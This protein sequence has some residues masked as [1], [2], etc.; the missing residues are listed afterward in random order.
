MG[1][2]GE[3][4]DSGIRETRVCS[5]CKRMFT[6][7]GFGHYYCP[8]CKKMD[9]E[10][11][12]RVRDYIYDHGSASAMEV[13]EGTGVSLSTITQYLKEGRLEI[14][15]NSLIF[16]KCEMCG[17]NIRS[18][19]LCRECASKLNHVMRKEIEF[20][21]EQIGEKPK[22]VSGKMRFLDNDS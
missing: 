11:F 1:Q 2:S 13:S 18:G 5:R 3:N 12:Q 21:D 8:T 16:I 9:E 15:E 4:M 7:L 10:Y 17:S 20:E 22:K 6:Y 14:P 19:R